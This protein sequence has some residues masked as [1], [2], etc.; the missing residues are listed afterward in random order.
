MAFLGICLVILKQW[1]K[2]NKIV[3]D[4]SSQK[5]INVNILQKAEA[6]GQA[7][8]RVASVLKCEA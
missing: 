7:R 8:A 1:Y 5:W 4:K 2:V 6:C 3:P